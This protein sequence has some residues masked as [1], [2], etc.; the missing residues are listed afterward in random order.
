MDSFASGFA[1]VDKTSDAGSFVQ[2]LDLIHSIPFFQECKAQSYQ[3]LDL[4]PGD[5]VLEIGCGN[6]IDLQ[7]LAGCVGTS[8]T[9]VGI[10]I[11]S[12][13]L[14]VARKNTEALGCS[15]GFLLCDG[16]HLAFPNDTFHAVRSDR[17]IQHTSDPFVALKEIVRVTRPLGT[18]V[19]FE[20]DWGTYTLWPGE[21]EICRRVMNFW[22]DNIPSGQVGRVLSAA[23]TDAGLE[24]IDVHPYT[25]TLTDLA[26]ARRIFDLNTTFSLAVQKG[27]VSQAD[28]DQWEDELSGADRKGQF[29]SSLTFFLVTGKKQ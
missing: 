22:C 15:P 5:S 7:K 4:L 12:T 9:A 28:I 11:S 14:S 25:L 24:S 20:P 2:Y 17:V 27:V 10:D 3:N 6:G 19:I 26:L 23:F 13:M 16:L 1:K 18:V 29:F 21:R 8:G